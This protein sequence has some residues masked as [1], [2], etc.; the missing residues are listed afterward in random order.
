M[1]I[2]ITTVL[3]WA[4]LVGFLAT[5]VKVMATSPSA[6]VNIQSAQPYYPEREPAT[7]PPHNQRQDFAAKD[8]DRV[9]RR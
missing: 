9:V 1:R 6:G 3:V 5:G 4:I 8:Y 2:L 7:R